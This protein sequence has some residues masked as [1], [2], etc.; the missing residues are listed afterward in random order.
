MPSSVLEAAL[1]WL[2]AP[3]PPSPPPLTR[4]GDSHEGVASISAPKDPLGAEEDTVAA[5]RSPPAH[6]TLDIATEA[7]YLFAV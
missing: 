4:D 1:A 2:A 3:S 6:G 5:E 7:Y